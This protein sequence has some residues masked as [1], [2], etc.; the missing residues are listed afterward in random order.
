MPVRSSTNSDAQAE[1]FSRPFARRRARM[2]RPPRVRI[3]I[4]NP[5]VLF[6]FRLL[7]WNV[8]FVTVPQ[9]LR[10]D[11]AVRAERRRA[12]R[13][14]LLSIAGVPVRPGLRTM[15]R[16]RMAKHGEDRWTPDNSDRKRKRFAKTQVVAWNRSEG[17]G[18]N[19][20]HF[21]GRLPPA[22]SLSGD[23]NF[24]RCG[25]RLWINDVFSCR[26]IVD[27]PA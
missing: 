10:W 12:A 21:V 17:R 11:S 4:L 7:G 27:G 23:L 9:A 19:P 8:R 25:K 5:C 3:L 20:P 26:A 13:L 1:M 24:H 6:R 14:L 18:Y 22:P 2:R 16:G 15:Y